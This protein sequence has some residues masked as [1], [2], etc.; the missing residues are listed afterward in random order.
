VLLPDKHIKIGESILGL[1]ALVMAN[2]EKPRAFD[3]LMAALAPKFG[4]SEWPAYHNTG[5]VSLALCFLHS[6]G[7][8]DVTTEGDLYRCD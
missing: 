3:N 4:T 8:V 5:T 6:A 7:L 1:A 2:L